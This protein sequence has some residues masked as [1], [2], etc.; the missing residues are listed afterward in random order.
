MRGLIWAAFNP[1]LFVEARLKTRWERPCLSTHARVGIGLLGPLD[2]AIKRQW[3]FVTA[4]HF[5][6]AMSF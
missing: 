2:A 5:W 4:H 6:A 1:L 3:N